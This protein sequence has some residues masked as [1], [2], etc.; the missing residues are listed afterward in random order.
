MDEKEEK[1]GD[2]KLYD[3][4]ENKGFSVVVTMSRLTLRSR[5]TTPIWWQW[6]T[7]SRI[8]WMQW[9]HANTKG[10][11]ELV[12]S[13]HSLS[14]IALVLTVGKLLAM[15]ARKTHTDLERGAPR[16]KVGGVLWHQPLSCVTEI[17][18][19]LQVSN[20][21]MSKMVQKVDIFQQIRSLSEKVLTQN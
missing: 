12:T 7:A 13:Y 2:V 6:S 11:H 17:Q 9:L 19:N 1:R 3:Q 16:L 20:N 5:W 8:C 15:L 4:E 18:P 10:G 14:G 21:F